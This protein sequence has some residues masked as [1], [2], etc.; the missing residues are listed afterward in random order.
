MLFRS[1]LSQ[2]L[3]PDVSTGSKANLTLT[4]SAGAFSQV[5][6]IQWDTPEL[7]A[8]PDATPGQDLW[9]PVQWAGMFP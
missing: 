1:F 2:Y 6:L 4:F 9:I 5:E 3:G 8:E 7:V